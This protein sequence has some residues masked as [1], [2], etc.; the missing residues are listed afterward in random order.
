M[1]KATKEAKVHTS[2]VNPYLAYDDAVRG[3]VTRLLAPGSPF[4]GTSRAFRAAVGARRPRRAHRRRV[5][6]P[7]PARGRAPRGLAGRAGEALRD[8]SRAHAE[9]RP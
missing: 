7:E 8:P 3:F 6:R 4:I 1:E 2:W 9:A 5:V